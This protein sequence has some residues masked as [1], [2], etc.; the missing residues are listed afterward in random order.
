MPSAPSSNSKSDNEK[1]LIPERR[2]KIAMAIPHEDGTIP[3]FRFPVNNQAGFGG[4]Q[5][6]QLVILSGRVHKTQRN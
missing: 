1:E 4:I 5:Q 2:V 3:H 6:N